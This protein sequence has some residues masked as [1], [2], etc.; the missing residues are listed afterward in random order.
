M[1]FEDPPTPK[2]RGT[3]KAHTPGEKAM[4]VRRAI[5]QPAQ[6]LLSPDRRRDRQSVTHRSKAARPVPKYDPI[7]AM[8][9]R[10]KVTERRSK[11]SL[12]YEM[13][14]LTSQG[15]PFFVVPGSIPDAGPG[16]CDCV[17]RA[18]Q[19]RQ[20]RVA[21]ARR[22]WRPHPAI[23]GGA[24]QDRTRVSTAHDTGDGNHFFVCACSCAQNRRAPKGGMG[25]S[26][27]TK[28]QEEPHGTMSYNQ[29]A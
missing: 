8:Q 18:R 19:D 2:S 11:L 10:Q 26:A 5:I 1:T 15:V 25:A 12:G 9:G 4:M 22:R 29:Q 16:T 20:R 24:V 13:H 17:R 21:R 14:R 27:T 7:G 6:P 23:A 3:Y 28:P